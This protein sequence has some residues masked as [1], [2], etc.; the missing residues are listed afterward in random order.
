MPRLRYH[1]WL[2]AKAATRFIL[3]VFPLPVRSIVWSTK[4]KRRRRRRG[5]KKVVKRIIEITPGASPA[6]TT[7]YLHRRYI[8]E[9][10][11]IFTRGT[12][13][14]PPCL[15]YSRFPLSVLVLHARMQ[16][17]WTI[18]R[19][20]LLRKA[21]AE[22]EGGAG[23]GGWKRK[24]EKEREERRGERGGGRKTPSTSNVRHYFFLFYSFRRSRK[25]ERERKRV[26]FDSQSYTSRDNAS[27]AFT[28]VNR[29]GNR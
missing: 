16:S 5:A 1:A 26:F 11:G 19:G 14:S 17:A 3:P 15:R 10:L 27:R 29:E 13:G 2:I 25:E 24:K 8:K 6:F 21:R 9:S 4:R 20:A 23:S 12:E 22:K 18:S 7:I 28:C